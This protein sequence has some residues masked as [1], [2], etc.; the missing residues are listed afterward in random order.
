M[1]MRILYWGLFSMIL[2]LS[3][4]LLAQELRCEVVINSQALVTNQVAERAIFEKLQSDISSF[5][6]NQ[7][8]T[9][10]RFEEDE[11]IICTINIT[12]TSSPENNVF[13]GTATVQAR[14]PVYNS[15]YET[16]LLSFNDQSFDF[17]YAEETR[18]IYNVNTFTDNLTSMLAFYAYVIL[19]M[20]YDSFAPEGGDTYVTRA[21]DIASIAQQSS[22]S[23]GWKRG[24]NDRN[25][26]ALI[27][28]LQSQQFI[29]FRRAIYEYHRLGLD[30]FQI[31]EEKSRE[32]ILNV[33]KTI[34]NVNRR[35]PSAVFTNIFFDAKNQELVNIFKKSPEPIRKQARNLLVI[36]DPTNTQRYNQLLAK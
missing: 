14:R 33:L 28:N 3:P 10:D 11:Q 20:D 6:N 30:A 12:L 1:W 24:Q 27:E 31:D 13:S 23:G 9:D 17:N 8:W 34:S 22:N 29:P 5:M 25:R 21:F 15:S 7:R 2:L 36:L 18:L 4:S 16:L 32:T 19:A 26:F 35:R